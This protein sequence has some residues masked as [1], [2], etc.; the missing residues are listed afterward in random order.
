MKTQFMTL[1][2]ACLTAAVVFCCLIRAEASSV[3]WGTAATFAVLGGSTVTSTGATD[4]TGD[5]G[6]SPGSAITGFPPGIVNGTIHAGDAVA[7]KAHS[8]ALIAYNTLVAITGATD[9]TGQNLG[10]R[11][12]APGTYNFSSSAQLTGTLIL[13]GQ[14]MV[15]PDFVIQIGSTLTTA[16]ESSIVLIN[17]ANYENIFFQ[18]GSSATLGTG[19]DFSG[20]IIALTSDTLNTGANVNGRIFAINGGITLDGNTIISVPEPVSAVLLA[21]GLMLLLTIRRQD[22]TAD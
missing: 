12:L 21:S 4:I 20:N 2:N 13:D 9:L 17:G 6:V 1:R 8:D 3:D 22:R 15:N 18:V 7:A 14:G 5:L 19:T 11:T 10:G 16:S